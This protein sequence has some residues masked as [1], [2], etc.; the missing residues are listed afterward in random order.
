MSLPRLAG[1]LNPPYRHPNMPQLHYG[2]V[3]VTGTLLVDL[4]IRHNN[5]LVT[6]LTVKGGLSAL[7]DGATLAWDYGSRAGTFTITVTKQDASFGPLIL[8][9]VAKSVVF[10]A[11]EGN[12]ASLY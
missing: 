12:S 11:L 10:E 8:A 5:F 1:G 9:T 6:S 2:L 4:G 7:A 3:S